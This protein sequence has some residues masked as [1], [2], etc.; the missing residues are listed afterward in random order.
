MDQFWMLPVRVDSVD[1]CG[2]TLNS[3]PSHDPRVSIFFVPDA[4]G[5]ENCTLAPFVVRGSSEGGSH[6]GELGS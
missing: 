3:A 2:L 6:A 5:P 1:S 4:V